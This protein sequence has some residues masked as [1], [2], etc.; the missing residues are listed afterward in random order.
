[1]PPLDLLNHSTSPHYS[2]GFVTKPLRRT[3]EGRVEPRGREAYLNSMLTD[4]AASPPAI[5]LVV[6]A[7]QRLQ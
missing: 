6:A 3:R 5:R 7:Y 4:R 1:M 2:R